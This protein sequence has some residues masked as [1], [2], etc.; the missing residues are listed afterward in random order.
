MEKINDSKNH[1]FELFD[2]KKCSYS[3]SY[4]HSQNSNMR[5]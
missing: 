4:V 1:R 5:F 2:I 3:I